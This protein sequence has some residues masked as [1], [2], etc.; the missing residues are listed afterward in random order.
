LRAAAHFGEAAMFQ[1]RT[2]LTELSFFGAP[3]GRRSAVKDEVK[4]GRAPDLPTF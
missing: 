2:A 1:A 3:G 4:S